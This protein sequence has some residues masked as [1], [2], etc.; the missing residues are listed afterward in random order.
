MLF[1]YTPGELCD[2]LVFWP[3]IVKILSRCCHLVCQ[4]LAPSLLD[5][6][7]EGFDVLL[8]VPEV[9]DLRLFGILSVHCGNN[10]G[11]AHLDYHLL[12][13]VRLLPFGDFFL[14]DEDVVRRGGG[15][16]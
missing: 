13:L 14:G 5:V 12:Q 15:G 2:V 16:G 4:D 7:E 9:F 6:G 1:V 10:G 11:N 3:V 8:S